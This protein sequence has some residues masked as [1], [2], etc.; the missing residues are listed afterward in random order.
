MI[1]E[2]KTISYNKAA[3]ILLVLSL[4]LYTYRGNV[5][6]MAAICSMIIRM[7]SR[8]IRV[9]HTKI[10]LVAWGIYLSIFAIL[11][12][13]IRT[14][15]FEMYVFVAY[16]FTVFNIFV[17]RQIDFDYIIKLIYNGSI[18]YV[19]SV[20]LQFLLPGVYTLI[21]RVFFSSDIY[22]EIVRRM[23]NGY[24][25]GFTREVAYVALII[26]AGLL[27][28]VFF[29]K[30]KHKIPLAILYLITL[31]ITGK[32]AHPVLAVVAI[33]LTYYLM[34]KNLKKHLKIWFGCLALLCLVVVT[35]PV[36]SNISFMSR[37]VVFIN[38]IQNGL[39]ANALTSGR[40]VIYQ[41]AFDLWSNNKM[42]GIGWE[43][44]RSLGAYGTSEYTTW[45]KN[46]DIHNCY[47]QILCETGIIGIIP[48]IVILLISFMTAIKK[49][50][51]QNSDGI[52]YSFAYFLFF[53]LYAV[54]EPCLF[55]DS[56]FILLF[57]CIG[58]IVWNTKSKWTEID[59]KRK[60]EYD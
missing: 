43:N 50:R 26:V 14:V 40:E 4:F 34:T 57:L 10:L 58:E 45:F 60:I 15:N 55:Q 24:M 6:A 2:R 38:G 27:Y 17:D 31:F 21:I 18:I 13:F 35:F 48:F 30:G 16:S 22:Y 32:K 39:D 52:R 8:K 51:V 47:L 54:S 59:C 3:D 41:R 12:Y 46:Y 23:S 53:W 5:G 20:W 42:F 33:M 11:L 19:L 36:W 56:Y 29:H 49:L 28:I 7:F 44:F 1:E 25:T 9:K 37:I